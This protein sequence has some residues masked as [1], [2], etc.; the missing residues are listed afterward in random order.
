M[1]VLAA[2]VNTLALVVFAAVLSVTLVITYWASK[3]TRTATEFWA[4]GRGISGLQN[5]FAVAGDYMSAASFLGFAGLIY[6]FGLDGFVGLVCA[7][8]AF[9]PVLLLLAQRMRNAGKFT[10]ADVLSF[11]LRER[12]ARVVAALGTLE[13]G[14]RLPRRADGR[15][16]RADPGAG[17]HRL[18]DLR[19]P[20]GHLHGRLRDLRRDARH[21]L[22]AD[23]QGRHADDGGRRADRARAGEDQLQPAGALQAAAAESSDG[24]GYLS[25]GLQ[26]PTRSTRISF[27]LAFLLGTAG[28]PHILMRFFTVPDARAARSSVW[29][30]VLL[31][32]SFYI[33]IMLVGLGARA[34]LGAGAEEAS[35]G[36]NLAAPL[37]AEE[38]GGG[39]GTVGGDLFLAVISAVA[40]ATILAVVAGLVISASGA[41]GPRPVVERR[42][43]E[44]RLRARGGGRG[45]D[46][47]DRPRH[48]RDRCLDPLRRGLQRVDP[49]GAG[50]RH[51]GEREPARPAAGAVLAALQHHGRDLRRGRRPRR[52]AGADRA[53]PGGVAGAGLR[54]LADPAGEP[55]A[56]DL[57]AGLPVL[58]ARY[59]A[60]QRGDDGALATTSSTCGPRPDWARR[61]PPSGP[62]SRRL[63]RWPSA[64]TAPR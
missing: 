45:Q 30:A 51:R 10:M 39:E 44:P 1:T 43:P 55:G 28:L 13:R 5:G 12:P 19:R 31:I 4:A 50:V 62:C 33:M 38:L 49:R 59:G 57:P 17:R 32:G 63:H 22:G 34:I 7:L 3:R 56:R 36:G 15:R 27:G 26:H 40:F 18:R 16:R 21:D 6:F 48:L 58:L 24:K 41:S 11:R 23:H 8:V 52:L 35:A 64:P 42:A 61:D 14:L 20:Y 37:L 25:G 2:G 47:R 29:W 54:R 53:Q 46:R 60:E 9:L